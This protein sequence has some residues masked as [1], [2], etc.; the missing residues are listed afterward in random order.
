MIFGLCL[1]QEWLVAC[2]AAATAPVNGNT[3][4]AEST[5]LAK[6]GTPFAP[7]RRLALD[8]ALL[9]ANYCASVALGFVLMLLVMSLN[10]GVFVTVVAGLTTGHAIFMPR[11]AAPVSNA[12]L[13]HS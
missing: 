6:A 13:C 10:V 4:P 2:R 9:S 3:S 12:A 5:P 7:P 1:L 8:R 11:T